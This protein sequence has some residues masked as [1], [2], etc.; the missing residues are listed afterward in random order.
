M[1]TITIPKELAKDDNLVA[2]PKNANKE[3]IDWLRNSIPVRT[4]NPTRS[5]LRALERGRRNFK[6]GNFIEWH[7]LRN[8]LDNYHRRPRQKTT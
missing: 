4:Y 6:V 3:F 5:E 7:K 2:I 8:E 1:V